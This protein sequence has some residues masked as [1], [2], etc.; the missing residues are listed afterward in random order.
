MKRGKINLFNNAIIARDINNRNNQMNH[1][2]PC[3][4]GKGI[5]KIKKDTN[6]NVFSYSYSMPNNFL[7][8]SVE[9]IGTSDCS[10]N[11]FSFDQIPHPEDNANAKY[12][13]SL[14]WVGNNLS[15][16]AS[17]RLKFSLGITVI[18]SQSKAKDTVNSRFPIPQNLQ[19]L[20]LSENNSSN[21]YSGIRYLAP[22][23]YSALNNSRVY[24]S[25]L[26]NEKSILASTIISLIR[27]SPHER[28]YLFERFSLYS[29][30]SCEKLS[31]DSLLFFNASSTILN[32]SNTFSF[33]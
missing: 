25:G 10:L 27:N 2:V 14:G 22:L 16:L 18:N 26:K 6:I 23:R 30:T 19:I 4:L 29:S 28:L 21:P 32:N 12:G 24:E 5:T 8:Y 3:L 11:L 15:A 1:N 7:I 13:I 20:C 31:S 9:N 33:S 17:N